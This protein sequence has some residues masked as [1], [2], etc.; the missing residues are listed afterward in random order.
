MAIATLKEVAEWK[1]KTERTIHDWLKAGAPLNKRGGGGKPNLFDTVQLDDWLLERAIAQRIVNN[2]GQNFDRRGEE[3]RLKHHQANNEALK[4]A[5][6]TGSL[7]PREVVVEL[8]S[9]GVSNARAKFSAVRIKIL[10]QFPGLDQEILDTIE[11]LHVNALE[12]LGE[13]GIP[14][15]LS[16]RISRYSQGME[17][18][19]EADS[20]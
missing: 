3:A 14:S 8:C 13:G 2:K 9:A 19:T 5:E 18:T 1:G 10:N 7:I 4:E 15:G 17:A 12:D 6:L 16:E 11:E 20:Q